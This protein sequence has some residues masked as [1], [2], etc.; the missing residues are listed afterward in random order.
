[1]AGTKK[2]LISLT[3]IR[4]GPLGESG[5]MGTTLETIPYI[6]PDS[7]VM[8]IEE[9]PITELFVE[10]ADFPDIVIS[11]GQRKA[12]LEFA[13]R[14]MG[15][16]AFIAAFGGTSS[17]TTV[18]LADR[19]ESLITKSVEAL[20]VSYN[21]SQIRLD[22]AKCVIRGNAELKYS[23]TDSGMIGFNCYVVLPDSD[24]EKPIKRVII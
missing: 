23:K 24:G 13:T 14:D 17:G 20:S 16:A 22:L 21:G 2:R 8:T 5:M 12:Y 7:A 1:M 10:D 18:W 11:A 3:Q 15:N 19:T 9:P 4:M 6:V